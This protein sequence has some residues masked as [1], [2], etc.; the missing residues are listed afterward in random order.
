MLVYSVINQWAGK[1]RTW[2]RWRH[3]MNVF[4]FDNVSSLDSSSDGD[5]RWHIYMFRVT[6]KDCY[7]NV[8]F[9]CLAPEVYR[10]MAKSQGC[11]SCILDGALVRPLHF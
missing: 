2:R 4:L 5:R 3:W 7:H 8:F 6:S 11:T 10:R 9:I 1:S